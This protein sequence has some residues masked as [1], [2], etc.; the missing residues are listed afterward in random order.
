MRKAQM[1]LKLAREDLT[2]VTEEQ[3]PQYHQRIR[4]AV[5]ASAREVGDA[6]TAREMKAEMEMIDADVN[7]SESPK[8]E[9]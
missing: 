1:L 7:C 6:E 2:S 4:D 5:T 3:Y 9:A 8:A